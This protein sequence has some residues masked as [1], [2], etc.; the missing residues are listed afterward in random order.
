MEHIFLIDI[1]ENTGYNQC[2]KEVVSDF[3]ALF[4]E[5]ME[6]FKIHIR[7]KDKFFEIP[8][9]ELSKDAPK[10]KEI[11]Y[12]RFNSQVD[13]SGEEGSNSPFI[14]GWLASNAQK[15]SYFHYICPTKKKINGGVFYGSSDRFTFS[16]VD[17]PTEIKEKYSKTSYLAIDASLNKEVFKGVLKHELGHAFHA[18]HEGRK[19]IECLPDAGCHCG[20]AG[21]IMQDGRE[22]D[23]MR[24]KKADFCPDC[25]AS[26]KEYINSLFNENSHTN[27]NEIAPVENSENLPPNQEKDDTFKHSWRAYAELVR[28]SLGNRATLEEDRSSRNF[29]AT[30]KTPDGKK[31]S[32]VA[33]SSNNV[34]LSAE[35]SDG[36]PDV[37]DQKVFDQLAK[38]ALRNGQE[39][40]FGDIESPEFKARL[41]LACL[42]NNVEMKNYPNMNELLNELN[43]DS[44]TKE[45]LNAFVTKKTP[46]NS[47]TVSS[48]KK[49]HTH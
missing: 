36:T 42:K 28:Y 1:S 46:Q 34:S 6:K 43:N 41:M 49:D 27:S 14:N 22:N 26:M 45:A 7:A 44:P 47:F 38:K 11:D 18:T 23:I 12:S 2:V 48:L 17:V 30:I 40:N 10:L 20:N 8:W 35:K 33:S 39:I 13:L 32:I 29:S 5:H 19:N 24:G 9:S 37:P 31:T 16:D 3:L 25:I 21:C 15:D 4:P